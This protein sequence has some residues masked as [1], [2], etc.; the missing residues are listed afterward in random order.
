M[1]P[2][3]MNSL[4]PSSCSITISAP[5]RRAESHAAAV[6]SSSATLA[7]VARGPKNG[8]R[9]DPG[10]RAA[11]VGLENHDQMITNND[12]RKLLSSQ[13]SVNRPRICEPT[14]A[15]ADD[16]AAPA[17]ICIVRVPRISNAIR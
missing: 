14:N 13:L 4:R 1:R 9:A 11:D 10:Q 2:L 16:H 17:T 12:P 8:L 6:A 15:T 3:S 7:A 5:I